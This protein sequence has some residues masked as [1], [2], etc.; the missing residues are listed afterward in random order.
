MAEKGVIPVK[1]ER[2]YYD[3][4]MESIGGMGA[5]LAGKILADAGVMGMGWNGLSFAAYGSEKKGT[6]VRTYVRFSDS[7]HPLRD[8][9]PVEEPHLLVLFHENMVK[10]L[11]VMRGL[12]PDGT[13]IVST[14]RDPDRVRDALRLH[15]GTLICVDAMKIAVEERVRVNTTLLGTIARGMEFMDREVLKGALR[16]K[17]E[18]KYPQLVQGNLNAFDR[19]WAEVK[20]KRFEPDGRYEYLP[21]EKFEPKLGY[22]T[23]PLGGAVINPGNTVEKDLSASRE[24]FIPVLNLDKCVHCADCDST[25][26]D[27]CFVWERGKDDKGKE[28]QFLRR[29]EYRYCKGCLRCVTVCPA[30]AITAER[31]KEGATA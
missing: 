21:F 8:G 4:R 13:V 12:R 5:N 3:V 22:A 15:A 24:G 31:E 29:I 19:G 20:V 7:D 25:C 18:E 11:P 28:R 30:G 10:A 27:Q 16:E 26:P 9:G 14:H 2:G 1:N 6:P 17:F 23:A